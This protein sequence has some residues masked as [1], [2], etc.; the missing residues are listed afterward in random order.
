MSRFKNENSSIYKW[1]LLIIQ[2]ITLISI[3]LTMIF[4]DTFFEVIFRGIWHL[5]LIMTGALLGTKEVIAKK[6]RLGYFY[7]IGIIFFIV[8]LIKIYNF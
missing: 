1:G 5:T 2:C 7:Y 8:I 3:I 4:D 6:N